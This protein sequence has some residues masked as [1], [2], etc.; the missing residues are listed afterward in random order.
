VIQSIVCRLVLESAQGITD[1]GIKTRAD[2]TSDSIVYC[3]SFNTKARLKV[4]YFFAD[5]CLLASC[6]QIAEIFILFEL[7]LSLLLIL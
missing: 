1:F 4:L 3:S 6:V 5:I 2:S 7:E